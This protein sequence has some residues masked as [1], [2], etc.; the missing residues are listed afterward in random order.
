MVEPLPY[1]LREEMAFSV[2]VV[3]KLTLF[4]YLNW[5]QKK[6]DVIS[7]KLQ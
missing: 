4:M 1:F 5:F 2:N 3:L 7:G 6:N